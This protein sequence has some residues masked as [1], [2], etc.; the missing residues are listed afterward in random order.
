MCNGS[1]LT[2]N[3]GQLNKKDELKRGETLER[4]EMIIKPAFFSFYVLF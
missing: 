1:L 3:K 2:L 4:S